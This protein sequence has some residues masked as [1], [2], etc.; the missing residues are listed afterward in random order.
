MKKH[1]VCS[2]SVSVCLFLR[3]C[4][5]LSISLSM[6]M[7]KPTSKP[8]ASRGEIRNP[9]RGSATV[10]IP[11]AGSPAD[12]EKERRCV[13]SP[14][15]RMHIM[16]LSDQSDTSWPRDMGHR[17]QEIVRPLEQLSIRTTLF[18]ES[19]RFG[20]RI[21]AIVMVVGESVAVVIVDRVDIGDSKAA[22]RTSFGSDQTC[23]EKRGNENC[24]CP[25]GAIYQSSHIR[26]SYTYLHHC[27]EVTSISFRCLDTLST[28]LP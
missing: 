16:V 9:A 27:L 20:V 26:Y 23:S 24:D 28:I 8:K 1:S 11:H 3:L 21:R 4:L 14:L 12:I 18:L 13:Q 17:T 2:I 19:F 7:Y 22:G 5:C 15:P 25:V 6:S 10:E